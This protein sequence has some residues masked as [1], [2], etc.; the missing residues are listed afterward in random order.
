M[1]YRETLELAA[2]VAAHQHELLTRQ[3]LLPRGRVETYWDRSQKRVRLWL[4]A[5]EYYSRKR[6]IATPAARLPLWQDLEPIL[7]EILVSEVL[8]RVWG[9]L[10]TGTD[11]ALSIK[12]YEP[13]ARHVLLG[14][15]DARQRGLNLLLN[16]TV[17]HPE[18]LSG[19]D[20][21]RRKVERWSDLL[22][23]QMLPH[24]KIDD[25]VYDMETAQ[26]FAESYQAE[27]QLRPREQVWS[28]IL[29]GLRLAFTAEP[30]AVPPAHE[31]LEYEILT[32][33]LGCFPEAEQH[34]QAPFQGMVERFRLVH[35]A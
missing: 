29:S 10:L 1:S 3:E 30:V 22:L 17:L 12:H 2:F 16:D 35:V 27:S 32:Q 23:G 14:H 8:T 9:A 13:I 34:A 15:L 5:I 33:I 25:F 18:H 24:C 31:Y 11:Q 28:L 21:L 26:D 19:I 20:R 7:G 4:S 6:Q